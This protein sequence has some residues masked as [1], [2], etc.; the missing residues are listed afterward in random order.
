MPLD[1]YLTVTNH[2]RIL[3][4][5]KYV[6]PVVSRR[7]GGV[8]IGINLNV[9]NACNWQCIYCQVPDLNRGLPPNVDL[10]LLEQELKMLLN[11]VIHGDFMERYVAIADRQLKDVAFSGN[12][13]PTS[14]KEFPQALQIVERVLREFDLLNND[15]NSAIRI[16][17][18]TNGS[19]VDQPSILAAIR[20]LATCNGEVWFKL[21][22]GSKAGFDWINHVTI[23]PLSHINRLIACAQACPTYIQTCMFSLDG[24]L[25]D[26]RD[27]ADYL[28]LIEKVKALVQGILL[29]SVARPSLQA[30]TF[31]IKSA[32]PSWLAH[33][34]QVIRGRGFVVHISP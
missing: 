31:R 33:V 15:S 6:Y 8:S 12:G 20:H 30:E 10:L 14:V 23:N 29:Y 9:N 25:P 34:G 21:D 27:L 13:E 17:L 5:M 19:L 7:A 4:G 11:E 24:V 16:R 26:E 18:I 1:Q 3:S 32:P 22:S 2:N 28:M